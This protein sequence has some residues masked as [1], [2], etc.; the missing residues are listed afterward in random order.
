M[1]DL[2]QEGGFASIVEAEKEDR[3]LYIVR[4]DPAAKIPGSQDSPSL[5]VAC[6][7]SDFAR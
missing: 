2:G 5:L 7:Y 4:I 6:R 1:L 3:V